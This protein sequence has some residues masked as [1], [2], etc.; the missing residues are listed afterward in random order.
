MPVCP[1]VRPKAPLW[2]SVG[3]SWLGRLG[4]SLFVWLAA[5]TCLNSWLEGNGLLLQVGLSYL[6]RLGLYAGFWLA[7]AVYLQQFPTRQRWVTSGVGAW[8]LGQLVLG[9]GQYS[10]FSGYSLVILSC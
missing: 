2:R 4:V 9:L 7:L 10:I 3:Q 6:A 5:V 1:V 8:L